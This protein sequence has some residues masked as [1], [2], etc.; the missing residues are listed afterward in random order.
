MAST[1]RAL[2]HRIPAPRTLGAC[3]ALALGLSAD[4]LLRGGGIG[5]TGKPPAKTTLGSIASGPTQRARQ[6]DTDAAR[7]AVQRG[8]P[9]SFQQLLRKDPEWRHPPP[10]ETLA[11]EGA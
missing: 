5:A 6:P 9:R 1:G 8:L 4:A 7:P 10:S 2:L 3:G 11:Q